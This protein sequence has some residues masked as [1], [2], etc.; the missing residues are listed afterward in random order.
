M[1][2]WML[3]NAEVYLRR[4]KLFDKKH[5]LELLAM[6]TN[7]DFVVTA[8]NAGAK[9]QALSGSFI[10]REPHGVIAVDQSFDKDTFGGKRPKLKQTRLYIF[11]NERTRQIHLITIGD[12]QTQK[13]D[14]EYCSKFVKMVLAQED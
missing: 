2:E 14:I 1:L 3:I 10:H 7:L 8:L 4:F 5:H 6:L 11:P 9:P 12:K 13:D